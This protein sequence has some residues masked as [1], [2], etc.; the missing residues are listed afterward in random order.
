[1]IKENLREE[2]KLFKGKPEAWEKSYL[3][4][5]GNS[6]TIEINRSVIDIEKA[7]DILARYKRQPI[8]ESK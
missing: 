1:L 7:E 3:R 4:L 5:S 8:R 6:T 2:S